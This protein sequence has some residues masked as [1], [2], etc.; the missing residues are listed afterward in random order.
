MADRD[1]DD[2]PGTYVFDGRR[3]RQGR[4][5]NA[6]CMSLNDAANRERFQSDEKAYLAG[7]GLSDAQ[8]RAVLD[9]DWLGLLQLGG[10]IY[11][12][13]KLAAVDGLTMQHLGG[14][15]SDMSRDEFADM[16][17]GGGRP[18]D[19]NRSSQEASP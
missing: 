16:M 18:I 6:F 17:I 15:M 11:Y 14:A 9:R 5:L 3:A 13:F 8:T 1:Y 12:T 10:N 4:A 19:G 7:F 2:I